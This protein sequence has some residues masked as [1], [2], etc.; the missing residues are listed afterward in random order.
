M[1][2]TFA[3]LRLSSHLPTTAW[4]GTTEDT[5]N[6]GEYVPFPTSVCLERKAN[7]ASRQAV[8]AHLRCD[9]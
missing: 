7:V 1:H 4:E 9:Q 6:T 8:I 3:S 2:W 5:E